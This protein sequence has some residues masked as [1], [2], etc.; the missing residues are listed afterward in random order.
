MNYEQT[1]TL[2]EVEYDLIEWA[3]SGEEGENLPAC[4]AHCHRLDPRGVCPGNQLEHG[5]PGP[6]RH[7]RLAWH[8]VR[9]LHHPRPAG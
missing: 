2:K 7:G 1:M 3:G 5:V 9:S 4:L 6:A 8:P